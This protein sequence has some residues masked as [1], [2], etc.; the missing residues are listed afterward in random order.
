MTLQ[1]IIMDRILRISRRM[2]GSSQSSRHHKPY[3]TERVA[4]CDPEERE[5]WD[6]TWLAY[7]SREEPRGNLRATADYTF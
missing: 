1:L 3:L 2:P 6:A 5:T 4:S 7:L